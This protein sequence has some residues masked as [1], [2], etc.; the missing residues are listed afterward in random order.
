MAAPTIAP[1]GAQLVTPVSG[2][3]EIAGGPQKQ[4]YRVTAG[5][6]VCNG[7][8]AVTVAAPSVTLT[9]TISISLSVVG[10][11]VGAQP[12]L[13][14]LTPGV[15]FTVAGSASDTSTYNWQVEG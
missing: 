3:V 6:F 8:S 13:K 4:Q 10:G 5:Q 9:S 11:T 1:S 7:A 15:G 2:Y 14:T 12:V